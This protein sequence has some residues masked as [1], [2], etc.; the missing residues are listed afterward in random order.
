MIDQTIPHSTDAEHGVIGAVLVSHK[1]IDEVTSLKPEHFYVGAHREI[2]RVMMDM[3]SSGKQIDVITLSETIYD[4]GLSD[5]TGGLSYLAEIANNVPSA[6]NVKRYAEIVQSKSI[7]RQ[8]LAA[9]EEIRATVLAVGTTKDKLNKAQALVMAV[10]E[11]RQQKQPRRIGEALNDY[12]ATLERRHAGENRGL[13]TGLSTLDDRLGGGLQDGNLI[14]VAG[15][16]SMGK[17]QPMDSKILLNDGKWKRFGD[18]CVGDSV[19]SIDGSESIVTGVFPQGIKDVYVVRFSDGRSAK[20]CAEHLWSVMNRKWSAPRVMQTSEVIE[21]LKKPS[22]KNRLYIDQVNGDF[23]ADENLPIDPWILGAYL[24]DGDF[25]GASVRFTKDS[26]ETIE[27]LRSRIPN[28]LELT[29]I[30]GVHW[31]IKSKTWRGENP[32]RTGLEILGLKG[33]RSHEKFIPQQYLCA[34]RDVRRDVLRGLL[35]TDGWVEKHGS[36][37]F[38]SSSKKLSCGV[39]DLARSLGYFAT[40][41]EKETAFT[42]KGEKKS[43]MT[44]YKVTIAGHGKRELFLLS[45]KRDRCGFS[46]RITRISFDSIEQDGKSD[47][48]CISVSHKNKLYVTDDYTVTH[49]TAFSDNIAINVAKAGN[50]AAIMSM[51]MTEIEQIDRVVAALGHVSLQDVIEARL[52]GVNGDKIFSAVG[53]LQELPLY[54]DEEAGLSV[55]AVM[56]KARQIKRKHGLRLLVVDALGI[57]DYDQNKAVSELGQITKTLKGFAKEMSIPV[58]LLCQLSR[59]CEERPDKRPV[60]SD[61]RDSGNIEQDADVVIMLYRDEYYKPDTMD[62]GIAEVLIRKNRQGKTGIVP[63]AFIGDQTRF[64]VLAGEWRQQQPETARPKSRGFGA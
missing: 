52:D 5:V 40:M 9:V 45:D 17:A 63:L 26:I 54:I 47:C 13:S 7:E 58:V 62:K 46:N 11:T 50:Q 57:M 12:V 33:L 53:K 32:I 16:P 29:G 56:S 43:G 15:R 18:V 6:A 8:L 27:N 39:Q 37:L 1:A 38:S 61:L 30:D 2:F 28:C 23:G 55:Q 25:C 42:N 41:I 22:M 35:D 21:L 59:K 36:V 19:A 48:Q 20:C 4:R 51:E 31:R 60:I 44:A 10:S 34:S 3:A 64:E 24:G 49:N 14:I